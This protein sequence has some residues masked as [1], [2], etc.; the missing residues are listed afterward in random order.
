METGSD[1]KAEIQEAMALS[2]ASLTAIPYG[3]VLTSEEMLLIVSQLFV[4]KTPTYTPDGQRVISVLSDED[5]E[6]KMK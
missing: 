6:K 4:S 3:R 5:I 2:L 1:V